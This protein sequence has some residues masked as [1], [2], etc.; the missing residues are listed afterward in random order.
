MRMIS[1][2]P[3]TPSAPAP[4]YSVILPLFNESESVHPLLN[5]LRQVVP[6]LEGE[7]EILLI[8]DGSRDSTKAILKE[9][10]EH[11][12][13]CRVFNFETNRGQAAALYFGMLQARGDI[14]ITLDGDGQNDPAD[15][16]RLLARLIS[17][18]ADMVV[19][20]REARQDSQLRRT[21]S[22][23][24]NQ[25]RRRLLNDHISDTGCALKVFRRSVCSSFIPIRTLYSFMP[26]LALAAG[27]Q[28]VEE[29]V[30]HRPRQ[31][32]KSSYGLGIML[33]K[34]CLDMLGVWWFSKRRFQVPRTGTH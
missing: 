23:L 30:R 24:A 18:G 10:G 34:P 14:I 20:V 19:G 15:I 28:V 29:K 31:K 1:P 26:A 11:W 7:V 6:E 12:P 16:P 22:V 2:A 5:E 4:T 3:N 33:W 8:N 13:D 27:F 21:M 25:V 9:I 32:G 17:S